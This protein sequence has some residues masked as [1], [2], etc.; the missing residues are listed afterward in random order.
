MT[1]WYRGTRKGH[2]YEVHAYMLVDGIPIEGVPSQRLM[3]SDR[4]T[5][6]LVST[7]PT[8]DREGEGTRWF[9]VHGAA[10][11]EN[12]P[13]HWMRLIQIAA[14]GYGIDLSDGGGGDFFPPP[15]PEDEGDDYRPPPP[16]PPPPKKP[17]GRV[18]RFLKRLFGRRGRR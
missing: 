11:A 7:N 2:T 13:E 14:A 3:Q 17:P 6:V 8:S 18:R 9:W 12:D 1:E 15:P 10:I 16:P 5:S 4:L